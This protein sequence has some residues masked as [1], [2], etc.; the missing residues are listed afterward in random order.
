M[1]TEGAVPPPASHLL[2][3]TRSS[4]TNSFSEHTAVDAEITAEKARRDSLTRNRSAPL[5]TCTSTLP[6]QL[7][8]D[9]D[10][11]R[12]EEM[13]FDLEHACDNCDFDTPPDIATVSS[14]PGWVRSRPSVMTD[15]VRQ[16]DLMV[17]P[18]CETTADSVCA[19]LQYWPDL[20]DYIYCCCCPLPKYDAD[21]AESRDLCGY[22]WSRKLPLPVCNNCQTFVPLTLMAGKPSLS[23]Y[24]IACQKMPM[25]TFHDQY[26]TTKR[27]SFVW[28]E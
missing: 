12:V 3:R 24:N 11:G 25:Q 23:C 1:N 22:I 2:N 10:I 21:G 20:Q 28:N 15:R 9:I 6:G 5:P 14:S 27:V 18:L 17:C 16:T 4:P 19:R 26:D 13:I 8:T 7:P